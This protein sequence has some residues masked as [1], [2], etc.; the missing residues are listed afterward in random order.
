MENT[1]K[2]LTNELLSHHTLINSTLFKSDFAAIVL[3][4]EF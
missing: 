3:G 1:K 4:C 2:N